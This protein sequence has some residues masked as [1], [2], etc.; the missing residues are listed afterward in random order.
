MPSLKIVSTP[1]LHW[2]PISKC[3]LK[4][5]LTL[6]L[7]I[8]LILPEL[9]ALFLTTARP[10]SQNIKPSPSSTKI[11]LFSSSNKTSRYASPPNLIH[12]IFLSHHRHQTSQVGQELLAQIQKDT[13]VGIDASIRKQAMDRHRQI[14][15][16]ATSEHDL[17]LYESGFITIDLIRW[18]DKD[19]G[20]NYYLSRGM[21]YPDSLRSGTKKPK[22][23]STE[24][25]KADAPPS[26]E[27]FGPTPSTEPSNTARRLWPV[28]CIVCEKADAL[29]KEYELDD[30]LSCPP[31]RLEKERYLASRTVTMAGRTPVLRVPPVV[32]PPRVA[33][34]PIVGPLE[35]PAPVYSEI[36]GLMDFSDDEDGEKGV[37]TKTPAVAPSDGGVEVVFEEEDDDDDFVTDELAEG[38]SGKKGKGGRKCGNCGEIG[39]YAKTCPKK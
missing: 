34:N 23:G 21:N 32:P 28:I 5:Q 29:P 7:S 1:L 25:N 19:V 38:A 30:R 33:P 35:A 39:H 9:L 26:S 4:T 17:W 20:R 18:A 27:Y 13:M 3:P 11:P 37:I 31:C 2:G 12:Y 14:I 6:L 10:Y 15:K 8:P 22:N 24:K 36:E 16:R